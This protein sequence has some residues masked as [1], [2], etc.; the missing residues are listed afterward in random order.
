MCVHPPKRPTTVFLHVVLRSFT[1]I[2]SQMQLCSHKTRQSLTLICPPTW[3]KLPDGKRREY[4]ILTV[5]AEDR[6]GDEVLE[7][8]AVSVKRTNH[9]T[10][11]QE[12]A[13]LLCK[14]PQFLLG[15]SDNKLYSQTDTGL[16]KCMW[17]ALAAPGNTQIP[18]RS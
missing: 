1:L 14:L 9:L 8:P 3:C 17:L 5:F 2:G 10:P 11:Y 6:R 18:L 16:T 4:Y 12:L 13:H 7:D 15:H